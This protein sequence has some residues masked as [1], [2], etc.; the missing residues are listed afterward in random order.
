ML[1]SG[2]Y[3][4]CLYWVSFL[5]FSSI[6]GCLFF[7]QNLGLLLLEPM[8]I[9][10]QLVACKLTSL[11]FVENIQNLQKKCNC[12][13]FTK[14]WLFC[15]GLK[16]WKWLILIPLISFRG[17]WVEVIF[18]CLFKKCEKMHIHRIQC[19]AVNA[20]HISIHDNK[21]KKVLCCNSVN[22]FDIDIIKKWSLLSK[23]VQRF[24]K[25]NSVTIY[26]IKIICN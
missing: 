3:C 4:T 10:C 12:I 9:Y 24:N 14:F 25:V 13:L 21:I 7:L 8:V 2:M 23:I 22:N 5:E 20:I 11:Q 17:Q 19:S 16:T 26:V 6:Y 15:S 1:K 18:L